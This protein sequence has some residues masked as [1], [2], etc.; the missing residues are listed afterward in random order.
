[1]IQ[2]YHLNQ[3]IPFHQI[4]QFRQIQSILLG[5]AAAGQHSEEFISAD[6][7]DEPQEKYANLRVSE[8]KKCLMDI[9]DTL[10]DYECKINQEEHPD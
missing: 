6:D 1:M 8:L 4:L 9:V 3:I 5:D 10:E 2:Q 7:E